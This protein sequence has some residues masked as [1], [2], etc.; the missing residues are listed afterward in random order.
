[1]IR[2]GVLGLGFMGR[3]HLASLMGIDGVEVVA[4]VA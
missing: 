1:M 3:S 4:G 2:F